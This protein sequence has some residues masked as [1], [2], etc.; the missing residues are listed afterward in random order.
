[1]PTYAATS[2]SNLCSLVEQRRN[3]IVNISHT[4][5]YVGCLLSYCAL[6]FYLEPDHLKGKLG[7]SL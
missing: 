4:F 7:M 1:M 6:W 5:R 3:R 2:P